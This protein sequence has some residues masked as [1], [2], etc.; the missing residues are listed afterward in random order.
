MVES[1][2]SKRLPYLVSDIEVPG[3]CVL[4]NVGGA[5]SYTFR[6]RDLA[7]QM[8]YSGYGRTVDV[9]LDEARERARA[10]R[11]KVREGQDPKDANAK[12][13][14]SFEALLETW[15]KEEKAK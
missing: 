12:H 13:T 14:E 8:K 15:A 7:G 6:Y 1:F 2:A 3:L 11:K 9:T 5:R 10:D 4:V